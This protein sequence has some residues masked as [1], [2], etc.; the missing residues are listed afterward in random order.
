MRLRRDALLVK[1]TPL[2]ESGLPLARPDTS[3]RPPPVG[4]TLGG[5]GRP[6][7]GA[8]DPGPLPLL[9]SRRTPGTIY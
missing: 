2:A 7:P 8:P 3:G 9:F 4:G 1:V 5:P 6:R